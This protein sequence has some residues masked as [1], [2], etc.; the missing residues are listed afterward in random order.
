MTQHQGIM[1]NSSLLVL[2]WFAISIMPILAQQRNLDSLENRL[3]EINVPKEKVDIL[4]NLAWQYQFINTTKAKGFAEKALIISEEDG[5]IKGW[6]SSCNTLGLISCDEGNPEKALK[7]FDRGITGKNQISDKKGV[8]TITCNKGI[9]LVRLRKY[10]TARTCY[11][12]ALEI[13][14]SLG[15]KRGIG[16]CYNQLGLLSRDLGD[17]PASNESFH[18]S[19]A[20]RTEIKDSR[21]IA[22]SYNN[23]ASNANDEGNYLLSISLYQ[24]AVPLLE[25]IGDSRSLATT[26]ANLGICNQRIKNTKLAHE[27]FQEAKELA[28][29]SGNEG[30]ELD[31]YNGSGDAFLLD[32]KYKL[33][34]EAHQNAIRIA[35]KMDD[36]GDLSHAHCGMAKGFLAENDL[37]KAGTFFFKA[38][39]TALK[40]G[41]IRDIII[42]SNQLADFLQMQKR[43]PEASNILKEIIRLA[44]KNN[45]KSYLAESYRIA[46]EIQKAEKTA[47][48]KPDSLNYYKQYSIIKD[49][50]FKEDLSIQ[51]AREQG[52]FQAER[53]EA[54]LIRLK[55]EKKISALEIEAQNLAIQK[56]DIGLVFGFI[57]IC[58]IGFA[59]WLNF[60]KKQLEII[61]ASLEASEAERLRIS[62]DIHDD[63]GSGLT[64]IRI[65]A[66]RE[67]N[68]MRDSAQAW[69]QILE[70]SSSLV[71]NMRDL[72][73]VMEP[74]TT[75]FESLISRIREFTHDYLQE[76][77]IKLSIKIEGLIPKKEVEIDVYRNLLMASKEVVQN[78]VTHSEASSVSIVFSFEN[79]FMLEI[80]DNGKGLDLQKQSQG[81][82][83]RNIE[84][85]LN[86]IQGIT[87]FETLKTGGFLVRM[88]IPF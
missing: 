47:L 28:I 84:T 83:L 1:K 59:F 63:F 30:T 43:Y 67:K 72:L 18:K 25:E 62:R 34:R 41:V 23:L 81:N 7:Y 12:S 66:G 8:A 48:L 71:E 51:I 37:E 64:R 40:S 20:L 35:E 19:L 78:I 61:R 55:Q 52:R 50:I 57:I 77:N 3:N 54:E 56:R 21:G 22:Y 9:A 15:D 27:Y 45:L 6:S 75:N 2:L 80:S 79:H 68:S 76:V 65:I 33:A 85:R 39:N 42:V 36:W 82:G 16:D 31:I 46:G 26:L 70:T 86:K 44:L 58:L 49:S 69:N 24:Q 38:R 73:W 4:N 13:R 32:K 88:I 87:E 14:K 17:Y 10:E 29:S 60:K 53:K 74:G 11:N 5:Y